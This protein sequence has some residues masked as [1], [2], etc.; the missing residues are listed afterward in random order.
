[1]SRLAGPGAS[2]QAI[3]H[4]SVALFNQ[5]LTRERLVEGLSSAISR[6]PMLRVRL[7]TDSKPPRW[8]EL[9]KDAV[10]IAQEVLQ[11]E[12]VEEEE[13]D[14][15]TARWQQIFHDGLNH[16]TFSADSPRWRVIAVKSAR[17][18]R[19]ALVF[20]VDHA[21]D[22]QTS[23]HL[24]LQH[25]LTPPPPPPPSTTTCP[26]PPSS[27]PP[28]HET[29]SL[30]LPPSV[31]EALSHHL[32]LRGLSWRTLLW[33]GYQLFNLLS[34]PRVTPAKCGAPLERVRDPA[35]RFTFCRFVD[36]T[37]EEVRGLQR[38]AK[39]RGLSLTHLLSAAVLVVTQSLVTVASDKDF[40]PTLLRFLLSVGLRPY[41][42]DR[43]Q[44][45]FTDGTVACA[46]GAVDY[47]AWLP[48]STLLPLPPS[49]SPLSPAAISNTFLESFWSLASFCQESS[50][51]LLSSWQVVPESVRLFDLGY[52]LVDIPQA[53]ERDAHGASF[54]RGYSCGLSNMGKVDLSIEKEGGR[55]GGLSIEKIYYGTSHGRNG[56]LMLLSCMTLADGGFSGCLQFP[57][58]LV[59]EEEA[60]ASVQRLLLLL[61]SL[62]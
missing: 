14:T 15:L 62:C 38:T 50:Q 37:A 5:S 19:T 23:I 10:E 16:A 21:I 35:Q 49:T 58:P 39:A 55:G 13:E 48:P 27:T 59:G 12:E 26:P 52:Q 24:I 54:G 61:R 36:L 8:E 4:A 30:P 47:L 40:S 7:V 42:V 41:G 22:D 32:P 51:R 43:R 18:Q 31:E 2:H 20:V 44:Q 46:A 53:V 57:G 25:I 33:A 45:D 34:R 6:H 9:E 3:A 29:T 11:V 1:M 28:R 17:R 56:V 60:D